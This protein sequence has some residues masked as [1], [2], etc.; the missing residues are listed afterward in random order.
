MAIAALPSTT[1]RLLNSAQVLTS[2]VSLVKEL[3]DNALDAKATSID[4]LISP[5]TLDKVEVRDNGHGIQPEDLD[6]LARHGYTSKLRSFEE[7]KRLGGVTL[8]FRGEALASAVELGDVTVTTKT[9]GESVGTMV[10]LKVTGGIDHQTLTSHPVGTTVSVKNFMAKLPV[11]KKTFEKE[12]AKSVAKITRLLQAYALA[13]PSIRLSLK[14]SKGGK[15]SWFFIPHPDGDIREAVLRA[16]GRDTALQC[17]D[18]VMPP[19]V[20]KHTMDPAAK[21]VTIHATGPEHFTI[22]A[23]LPAPHADPSKI[24]GGQF[25]SVDCRPVSHE[26]GTMKK[27]VTIFKKYLRS[28]LDDADNKLKSPFIRLNIKCPVASYDA[29]VEPAK[30]EVLFG[31]EDLLLETVERLFRDV[32]GEC[33]APSTTSAPRLS[34][35]SRGNIDSPIVQEPHTSSDV[36]RRH[37][38]LVVSTEMQAHLTLSAS[39]HAE[40]PNCDQLVVAEHADISEMHRN[41]QTKWGFD[42]SENLSIDVEGTDKRRNIYSYDSA[43]PA[44]TINQMHQRQKPR[45]NPWTI[46]KKTFGPT[47]ELATASGN[48]NQLPILIPTEQETRTHR[49]RGPE[50]HV[51]PPSTTPPRRP[52]TSWYHRL[53]SSD[54]QQLPSDAESDLFITDSEQTHHS[55]RINGFV[56]AR[57]IVQDSLISPPPTQLSKPSSRARVLKPLIPPVRNTLDRVRPDVLRQTKLLP[58]CEPSTASIDSQQE[59]SG[60][61]DLVWAMDFEKRKEEATRRRREEVRDLREAGSEPTTSKSPRSSP[62]KNRY[63]AAAASLEVSQPTSSSSTQEQ[64]EKPFQTSLSEDDPRAYFMRRRRSVN[65]ELNALGGPPTLMRT[66]STR[67]PLET[68]ARE[69]QLQQLIQS[70]SVDSDALHQTTLILAKYN[71]SIDKFAGLAIEPEDIS[72]LTE[73]LQ[74]MVTSKITDTGGGEVEIEYTLEK[75]VQ[76]PLMRMV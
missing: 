10:K 71:V 30:D 44:Q 22:N 59:V 43:A 58:V 33:R 75:A 56:T 42:M 73:K 63:N 54:G 17:D 52:S 6:A 11:R 29:N 8:G 38:G 48:M 72:V 23:F 76:D 53:K 25:M 69:A 68:V 70:L 19:Q 24:G 50:S 26:K 35:N 47:K 16:I 4:I 12:A 20:E 27:I 31:N 14:V 67:L 66:R 9:E 32:Y 40:A 65:Y 3:I 37:C 60:N 18:V 36:D 34:A 57:S 1:V 62:H 39:D 28:S 74:A 2:P 15:G 61:P 49:P 41:K 5:N 45:L 7:L 13:R 21:L 46:A 51:L 55:P 64:H